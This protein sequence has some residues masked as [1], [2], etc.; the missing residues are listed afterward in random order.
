[1]FRCARISPVNFEMTQFSLCR[2]GRGWV[3]RSKAVHA[4]AQTIP[5]SE[6]APSGGALY[7]FASSTGEKRSSSPA[8]LCPEKRS[9]AERDGL[10]EASAPRFMRL[11]L[12]Q[13]VYRLPDLNRQTK[14]LRILSLLCL[15]IS[16]RRCDV[17]QKASSTSNSCTG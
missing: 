3:S 11:L 14:R 1:L 7:P 12:G 6:N 15:P 2:H 17:E 4:L 13:T 5:A 8:P 10:V 16:P 9:K